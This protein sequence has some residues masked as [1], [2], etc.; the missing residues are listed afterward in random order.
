[1]HLEDIDMLLYT[2]SDDEAISDGT[3]K[4][5]LDTIANDTILRVTLAYDGLSNVTV[6]IFKTSVLGIVDVLLETIE[7]SSSMR[8]TA[9][10][11]FDVC[12]PAGTYAVELVARSQS[13]STRPVLGLSSI[14]LVN[15]MNCAYSSDGKWLIALVK[16]RCICSL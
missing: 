12:I 15:G 4:S 9:Q 10:F 11:E 7:F 16:S 8:G 3:V 2:P 13:T 14:E 6:N 5:P 1:V